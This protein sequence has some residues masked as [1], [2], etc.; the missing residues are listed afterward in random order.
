MDSLNQFHSFYHIFRDISTA[1][2][3]STQFDEAL[4]MIVWRTT[5]ILGAKGA[6]IRILTEKAHDVKT[7]ASYG[8]SQK[9]LSKNPISNEKMIKEICRVSKVI[10]IDDIEANP[11]I[12]NPQELKA[13]GIQTV[14]DLPLVISEDIIGMLRLHFNEQKDCSLEEIDLLGA[15]AERCACAIDKAFLLEEKQSQYNQL[16][17]HTEK[18]SALGRM[19]AG[20]AHEI[21]NPLAGILLFSTNMRKKV[22][23]QGPLKEGLDVI[24][25]E[26]RRCKGIIQDLL[27]FSRDKEPTKTPASINKIIEASLGILENE[28]RL[29]YITIE[30][31]LAPDIPDILLDNN[32]MQQVFVNLLINAVEAIQDKGVITIESRMSPDQKIVTI[33]ITDT[34]TGI[35]SNHL[36]NIFE[37][38][39]ST[40]TNGTGLGLAVSF[41]IIQ[42]HQ[43][44]IQVDS[45]PG[46]GTRFTIQIPAGE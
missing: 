17:L 38:F 36:T 26:T 42:K 21:N 5:E 25:K 7:F 12:K 41:G 20:I 37:P 6:V 22:P 34:G 46:R 40:K 30:K 29:H 16:A 33:E 1:V 43:G 2:G 8:M 19:A 11:R 32:L 10:A 39:F 27:E 9:Y 44:R 13:E 18:L 3:A 35:H 14:L 23:D 15:I 31:R 28:F 4:E 45:E 24:I